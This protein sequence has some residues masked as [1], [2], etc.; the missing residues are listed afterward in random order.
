MRKYQPKPTHLDLF[1]YIFDVFALLP[2]VANIYVSWM[3]ISVSL[4]ETMLSL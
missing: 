2:Y 1:H 4:P 3:H